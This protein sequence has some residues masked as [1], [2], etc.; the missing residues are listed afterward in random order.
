MF[1]HLLSL[2]LDLIL[3][4]TIP[5]N[6]WLRIACIVNF[7]GRISCLLKLRLKQSYSFYVSEFGLIPVGLEFVWGLL[8]LRSLQFPVYCTIF[9]VLCTYLIFCVLFWTQSVRHSSLAYWFR[10]LLDHCRLAFV[11]MLYFRVHRFC[12][13]QHWRCDHF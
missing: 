5:S 1:I 12:V 4:V 10:I 13:V 11:S 8:V 9:P 3:Y 7:L 6:L 2:I